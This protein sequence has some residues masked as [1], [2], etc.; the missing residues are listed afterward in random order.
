MWKKELSTYHIIRKIMKLTTQHTNWRSHLL[1]TNLQNHLHKTI[2]NPP[3][4]PML[5]NDWISILGTIGKTAKKNAYGII[6][7]QTTTNYKKAISKYRNTLN[8]QP[9]RIHSNFQKY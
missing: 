9:K 3:N 7:K 5:V 8:L 6:I 4:D 1:I 2:P